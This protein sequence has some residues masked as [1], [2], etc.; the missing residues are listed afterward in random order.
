MSTPENVNH[1]NE[2]R[3]SY[4]LN[5]F[6]LVLCAL[7]GFGAYKAVTQDDVLVINEISLSGEFDHVSKQDVY[8]LI[9]NG[10]KGNF[11]TVDIEDIYS[12]FYTMDWVEQIWV[13]RV[14]PN[15]INIVFNEHKPVAI[16][17]G[18][19]LLNDKG[20]VFVDATK[21]F[22]DTLPVFSIA[23]MY[24]KPAISAF[25]DYQALLENY[26][27]EIKSFVFDSRKSQEIVLDNGIRLKLGRKN[28]VE[29]LQRFVEAYQSTLA[30]K[31][32][33]IE[34]VDLRYTNGFAIQW[35]AA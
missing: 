3:H 14:W 8:S 16:I 21:E 17:D 1:P 26:D 27:F 24:E 19:G 18:K 33:K 25:K 2:E 31:V 5:V 22:E 11:F 23:K 13:H 12:K 30:S 10:V 7:L 28:V 34:G 15:K 9:A 32:K 4:L 20:E 6:W 29:R 35:K